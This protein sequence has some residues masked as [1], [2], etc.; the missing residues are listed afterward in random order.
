MKKKKLKKLIRKEVEK[1]L[2]IYIVVASVLCVEKPYDNSLRIGEKYKIIKE[3]EVYF[4]IKNDLG[5]EECYCRKL[6]KKL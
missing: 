3:H 1:Q 4:I 5:K 2:G 6:F